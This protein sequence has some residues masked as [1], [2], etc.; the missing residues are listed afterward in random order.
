MSISNALRRCLGGMATALILASL[1]T[2][3][4]A[5]DKRPNVVVIMTDDTG[6]GD[7]GA[8]G[9][10]KTRNAPT[11]NLDQLAAGG[12]TFTEWYGQ[13]SC[14]AGR[15]SFI[16]GRIPVRSALS[17]VIAPGDPNKIRPE[18]PTIA[19]FF[20]KNG[21]QTYFSGKWHLGDTIDAM[22]VNHGFDT[23][24]NFL[25]Y[26]SGVY[27]YTD[28]NLHPDFPRDNPAFMAAY[29]Q[30]VNDGMWEGEAG[31]PPRRVIEHFGYPDLATFDQKQAA[32][33]AGY[34]KEHANDTK[35]MFMYVSF[36]KMH[37]PT[38]PAPDF[39]G[40]S[41]ASLY[42]DSLMEMDANTGTVL[43][44]LRTAGIDKNTIVLWT[45]DNGAWIDAYPDAGYQPFRGMK[46]TGFEGG[47]RV[48]TIMSWP[49]HIP[50]GTKTDG[51]IS[52]MDF[53]PTA[54]ALAGLTPP[55]HGGWVG[56]DG[57][58]IYFDGIDNSAFVLGKGKSARDSMI[59]I[60][61]ITMLGLRTGDWKFVWTAKDSWLG[62]ELTLEVPAIYNL[63]QD[64]GE[65]YDKMFNG[66]APPTA[67]M[68]KT[69]PGRWSGQDS[70]W[71]L[72]MA[73]APFE[74]MMKSMK[75]FPNTDILPSPALVGVDRPKF[76]PPA[77]RFYTGD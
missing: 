8:F 4:Q 65:A 77:M 14:T 50:A 39:K 13:A 63:K 43:Q 40:K 47:W 30:K 56:N 59:Y 1:P 26:Y 21:Y 18:T 61:G 2:V 36:T 37:N 71:A 72:M 41:H 17:V 9:G 66:A 74:E 12:T 73:L 48:P 44:A 49:G 32:D 20:R 6:W 35:P 51:I 53:W 25:A 57:K 69:S 67:G 31:Q 42:L 45:V 7:L 23:M 19:E 76:V 15:A 34:I 16:T 38:N 70:G 75:E 28:T 60:E 10:G 55:P 27:A 29:W 22:P 24:K 3:A 33:A 5:Q 58:P 52:H 54:A 62:P 46:G 64:P 68:L 11:P